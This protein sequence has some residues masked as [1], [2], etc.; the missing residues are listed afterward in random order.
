MEMRRLGRSDIRV[1]P[2]G[3]GCMQFSGGGLAGLAIRTIGQNTVDRI[4]EVAL[5]AGITW[6][7]TAEMYGR[8]RSERALAAALRAAGR[9]PGDVVVATKWLPTGRFAGNIPRTVGHRLR[10][11]DPYPIDLYQIHE[12]F[13]S[14]SSMPAQLRAMAR[15]LRAGKI[16][17]VGVSNVGGRRLRAAHRVLRDEGIELAANQLQIN[18]VHR[19][20]EDNGV[21]DAARELG[22]SLIAYSPLAGGLLTGRYHDAPDEVAALR[23]GRRYTSRGAFS[24][25]GLA[26]TRPLITELRAIADRHHATPGQVALSW[27]IRYYG[28]TVVA[29]PGASKPRH[30]TEAAGAMDVRLTADELAR[31]DQLSR[32]AVR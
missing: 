25:A 10:A 7:D 12:P 29:I 21:L 28:D 24:A 3:L 27:L 6:F 9:E 30:A 4:V 2:I 11:L 15:V 20:I 22:I 14:L 13:S 19:A 1:S 17:A 32:P 26:R 8:G 16:R 23:P 5:D 31:L 18:L